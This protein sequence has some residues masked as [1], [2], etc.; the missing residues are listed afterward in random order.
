MAEK[1]KVTVRGGNRRSSGLDKME[2]VRSKVLEQKQETGS[3]ESS[4]PWEQT[5]N[6][7]AK[8]CI[9]DDLAISSVSP[10]PK[11]ARD[12]PVIRPTAEN[13]FLAQPDN[14]G[15]PYV[16]MDK[17][18]ILNK[19]DVNHPLYKH[20]EKQIEEIILLAE[21]IRDG[22]GIYQPIEV[23]RI[24]GTDYRIVF[25]HRRFYA[26]VYLL[27]WDSVWP[28]QVHR[29]KPKS[30][31]LRQFAENNSR[32]DLAVHEKISAFRMAYEEIIEDKTREL[33]KT[34]IMKLMGLNRTN[35][36]RYLAYTRF[37]FIYDVAK[38]GIDFVNVR[39]LEDA[40]KTVEK[41]FDQ[42][43][44]EELEK[45]VKKSL[46][47]L[48]INASKPVPKYLIDSELV[49]DD[50]GDGLNVLSTETPETNEV[51]ND[52]N[53]SEN[54][55]E[56]RGRKA[57]YYVPPRIKNTNAVKTLLTSDVTKMNIEGINWE[58]IDWED[59]AQVNQCLEATI[60]ALE[61]MMQ[62]N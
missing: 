56:T 11:N 51:Q 59:R 34:D 55:R 22:G 10:D 7:G 41:A 48:F 31:K 47:Q 35:F 8:D 5:I 16:V 1:S 24:G 33:T 20:I 37:P 28:F 40:I 26:V 46:A 15:L 3:Q 42:D 21:Q 30:P 52:V 6:T 9:R 38:D 23:Y 19:T 12:F 58:G 29:Q 50:K 44:E 4:Q 49:E 17:G 27:G 43:D 25:G 53:Q 62:D 14:A 57:K 36:Y 18:E 45:Q 39:I 32:S 2:Q 61:E 60:K 54:V 13:M